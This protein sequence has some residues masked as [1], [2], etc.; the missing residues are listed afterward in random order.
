MASP[1]SA[2]VY[3]TSGN[4]WFVV[5]PDREAELDADHFNPDGAVHVRVARADYDACPDH[6]AIRQLTVGLVAQKSPAA[7]ANIQRDIG[8]IE[9]L[10]SAIAAVAEAAE[11]F[12]AAQAPADP[13]PM[14]SM[15]KAGISS[16]LGTGVA[17]D[18]ES[19]AP[20]NDDADALQAAQADFLAA[21]EDAAT[22]VAP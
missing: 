1:N 9:R 3:D 22:V 2:V 20:T 16:K 14:Q 11:A 10:R 21:Q 4:L 18:T 13:A 6:H 5:H 12:A 8:K 17:L 19:D 7:A 15:A